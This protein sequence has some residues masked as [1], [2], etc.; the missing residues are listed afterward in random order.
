MRKDGRV[1]QQGGAR[2]KGV[3]PSRSAGRSEA[4]LREG[5]ECCRWEW[6]DAHGIFGMCVLEWNQMHPLFHLCPLSSF[7]VIVYNL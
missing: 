3:G 1:V 5:I 6:N 7:I 2:S 4:I